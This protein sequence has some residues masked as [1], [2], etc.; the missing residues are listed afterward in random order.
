MSKLR[1]GQFKET[2]E[3]TINKAKKMTFDD[4]WDWRLKQGDRFIGKEMKESLAIFGQDMAS[5]IKPL[6]LSSREQK[7]K[8][9]ENENKNNVTQENIEEESEDD[10]HEQNDPLKKNLKELGDWAGFTKE[11]ITASVQKKQK[12]NALAN[13][14]LPDAKA[15][16]EQQ[17]ELEFQDRK[18]RAKLKETAAHAFQDLDS[19]EISDDEDVKVKKSTRDK[20][21]QANKRLNDEIKQ[22]EDFKKIGDVVIGENDFRTHSNN[23]NEKGGKNT[24]H[25]DNLLGDP[26]NTAVITPAG[27]NVKKTEESA[28]ELSK[29]LTKEVQFVEKK[30]EDMNEEELEAFKFQGLLDKNKAFKAIQELVTRIDNPLALLGANKKKKRRD[31]DEVKQT[32]EEQEE[33][34]VANY[35]KKIEYDFLKLEAGYKYDIIPPPAFNSIMDVLPKMVQDVNQKTLN[36]KIHAQDLIRLRLTYTMTEL[37]KKKQKKKQSK[38]DKEKE[39]NLKK[40]QQVTSTT[41]NLVASTAKNTSSLQATTF[42]STSEFGSEGGDSFNDDL[43]LQF[44][45]KKGSDAKKERKAMFLENEKYINRKP[46]PMMEGKQKNQIL[47]AMTDTKDNYRPNNIG[48]SSSMSVVSN[49]SAKSR[50]IADFNADMQNLTEKF[51][52]DEEDY[53]KEEELLRLKDPY[54][55]YKVLYL[56]IRAND[57]NEDCIEKF[58]WSGNSIMT[59]YSFTLSQ[60]E[61]TID[62]LN[63]QKLD[64][65]LSGFNGFIHTTQRYSREFVESSAINGFLMLSVFLNTLIL[66]GDGLAPDSWSDTF[67]N[68][69]LAFTIIFTIEMVIKMYGLGIKRYVKDAFNVFDCFVV[70]LSLVELVINYTSDGSGGGATSGFRAVRIFR[71]FRVLRVTRLLRSLRF[72][73]VIIEVIKSTAEQFAYITIL[74]FLFIFIFTL[75]GTQ[76]F[77]GQFTFD[78]YPYNRQRYNFD[79]FSQAF[80]TVFTI[81]TVENWNGVLVNCLRSGANS[82]LAIFYLIVWI[83]IGNYI[84]VNLFL[85]I[86]LDGFGSSNAMQQI[87]EIQQESRELE[88]THKILIEQEEKKKIMDQ[89]EKEK[90]IE[91]VLL[92]IDPLKHQSKQKIKKNQGCYL[93]TRDDG[94]DNHSLSEEL[95][96]QIILDKT[97]KSKVASNNPYE[98]VDCIKSLYYFKQTNLIRLFAAR[99]CS[100]PK[101]DMSYSDL[102]CSF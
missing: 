74:M 80:F 18:A 47:K 89:E 79:S 86:L 27:V 61:K 58:N 92:I 48:I 67:T 17:K 75:L 56:S 70:I 101:Y 100:H 40:Q 44:N 26:I 99:V 51:S 10:E 60:T 87:E 77:G 41:A 28:K 71:I 25:L 15:I 42:D 24:F 22:D 31:D 45:T 20:T 33:E 57:T 13:N 83:F 91:E 62:A 21:A 9:V 39:A 64:L 82:I 43:N 6:L 32:P 37:K 16:A 46:F 98:G 38:K 19:F 85:S 23:Q 78:V 66:A 11:Q 3:M 88:R 96:L 8:A 65:W 90:A 52:K 50:A 5:P 30:E 7:A 69:N 1:D 12:K 49:K 35:Y 55:D 4:L 95:D 84:F 34:K 2:K 68:M 73:K 102:K 97:M 63:V 54:Y 14:Y 53:E 93:V 76:I 72:M 94:Q 36:E 81:L 29:D 59:P